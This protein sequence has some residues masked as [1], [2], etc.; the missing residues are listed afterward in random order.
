M[1]AIASGGI[2]V[3]NHDVIRQLGM[4]PSMFDAAAAEQQQEQ[5]ARLFQSAHHG[6]RIW[7]AERRPHFHDI[8]GQATTLGQNFTT[9]EAV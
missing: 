8:P 9:S 2:R 6:G 3:L 1:G 4:T 7:M 5:L